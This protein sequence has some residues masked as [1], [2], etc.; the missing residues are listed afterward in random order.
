MHKEPHGRTTDTSPCAAW[1][2]DHQDGGLYPEDAYCSAG[3]IS[4]G[5][6]IHVEMQNGN[7]S[8][9]TRIDL[10]CA[11]ELTLEDAAWLSQTLGRLHTLDHMP[12]VGAALDAGDFD[13]AAQRFLA[14]PPRA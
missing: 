4:F 8:G 13:R 14:T 3:T 12:E 9:E 6:R 10:E 5:D 2:R 7:L 11:A 1:C